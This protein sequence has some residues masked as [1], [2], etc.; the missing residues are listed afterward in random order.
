MSNQQEIK[1]HIIMIEYIPQR[2]NKE[3]FN[4]INYWII[5]YSPAVLNNTVNV[6]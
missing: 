2:L 3:V 4:I 6:I 1:Y 5:R